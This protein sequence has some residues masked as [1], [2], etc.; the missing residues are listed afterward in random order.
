MNHEEAVDEGS[1]GYGKRKEPTTLEEIY[2]DGL[3]PN[4]P[5]QRSV[6]LIVTLVV[7]ILSIAIIWMI[8]DGAQMGIFDGA[9]FGLVLLLFIAI[10]LCIFAFILMSVLTW[11]AFQG[12]LEYEVR[13]EIQ[14]DIAYDGWDMFRSNPHESYSILT[15]VGVAGILVIF[16][17]LFTGP[18]LAFNIFAVGFTCMIA[19]TNTF[20]K[21]H[22]IF[23]DE[24]FGHILFGFRPYTF[25]M[26]W[27]KFSGFELREESI[28]LKPERN[29]PIM[30]LMMRM[31]IPVPDDPED[32]LFVLQQYL[33]E[34]RDR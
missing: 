12:E 27:D 13:G 28:I 5:M 23:T 18:E 25:F 26:S 14:M 7:G 8:W 30:G 32:A 16:A 6:L 29:A 24:G 10:G 33:P 21:R 15:L 1:T 3:K 34:I 22:Y 20:A 17:L 19:I 11:I 4:V 31:K 9:P 2:C